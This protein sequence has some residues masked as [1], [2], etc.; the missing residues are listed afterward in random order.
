MVQNNLTSLSGFDIFSSEL[1]PMGRWA[2]GRSPCG[3]SVR[4][5][6]RAQTH[7]WTVPPH[8]TGTG[9]LGQSG[10]LDQSLEKHNKLGTFV[11]RFGKQG[12]ET[13]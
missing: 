9:T 2:P 3:P 6:E 10:F 4:L 11:S 13:S 7:R 12:A 8:A 5:Y 1:L